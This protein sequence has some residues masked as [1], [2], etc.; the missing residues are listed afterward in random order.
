[1][2]PAPSG[3]CL[4]P[5]SLLF[6][7]PSLISVPL[8]SNVPS[9]LPPPLARLPLPSP[10]LAALLAPAGVSLHGRH[11]QFSLPLQV[12]ITCIHNRHALP[13][14]FAKH[15]ER[16]MDGAAA[17]PAG[18]CT[19]RS[20]PGTHSSRPLPAIAPASATAARGAAAG[21]RLKLA[22]ALLAALLSIQGHC[23]GAAACGA[24]GC[25]PSLADNRC[26]CW[27]AAPAA[28]AVQAATCR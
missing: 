27:R 21:R 6:A 24:A 18:T 9:S 2:V 19:R 12:S 10:P 4:P 5:P 3:A 15:D 1:M 13:N 22:A 28:A 8:D 16:L 7:C 23:G 20:A 25:A 17:H 11:A 14:K 26:T